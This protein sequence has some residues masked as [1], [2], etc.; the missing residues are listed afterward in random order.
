MGVGGIRGVHGDCDSLVQSDMVWRLVMTGVPVSRK[1]GETEKGTCAYHDGCTPKTLCLKR[2]G[3][4]CACCLMTG[5][6][7]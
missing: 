2:P 3:Q 4:I 1:K 5:M 7:M 6:N